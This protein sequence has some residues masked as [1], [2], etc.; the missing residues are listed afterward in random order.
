MLT[1]LLASLLILSAGRAV[2]GGPLGTE[3]PR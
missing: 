1:L 2:T 3:Q